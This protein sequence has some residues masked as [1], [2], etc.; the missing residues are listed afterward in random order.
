MENYQEEDRTQGEANV[1][2]VQIFLEIDGEQNA[3]FLYIGH[4]ACVCC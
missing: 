3:V 2:E 1:V 4:Y